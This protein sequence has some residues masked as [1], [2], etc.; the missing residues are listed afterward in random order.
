M[1]PF[2]EFG[3]QRDLRRL[4][5]KYYG[6]PLKEI[7]ATELFAEIQPIIY[8]YQL[9]VPSDYWLLIKTLVV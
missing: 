8:E 9:R 6:L 2:D 4:L 7:S 1:Q 3:L 5:R